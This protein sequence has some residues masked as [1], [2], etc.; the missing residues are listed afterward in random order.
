MP[1]ETL[2]PLEHHTAAKHEILRCYLGAWFPILTSGG[3]NRRD[4]F[5]YGIAVPG[6][7]EGGE[8][9]SPIIALDTL[10]NHAAFGVTWTRA[11][12][13]SVTPVAASA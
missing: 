8:L 3:F 12:A 11:A 2:W 5:L 1:D 7:Y 4:L 6:F 10:V 13:P 9:G